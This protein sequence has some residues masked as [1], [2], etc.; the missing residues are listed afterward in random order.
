MKVLFESTGT[1][2][3]LNNWLERKLRNEPI[4]AIETAAKDGVTALRTNTPVGATG[5]TANGWTYEIK[6][7][8]NATELSFTNNA[9]PE[10][11]VNVAKIIDIGHGTRNGGYVAA[12]PYIRRSMESVF[13]NASMAIAEE[14]IK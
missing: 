4:M 3:R 5:E 10:A 6:T 7:K 14:M 12:R 9:H 11:S 8:R 13:N 1:F 2:E